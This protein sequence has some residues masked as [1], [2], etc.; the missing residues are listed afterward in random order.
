MDF[1]VGLDF[2]THQ[3]K[4]CYSYKPNN[5][6]L[7][8]Y[9]EF[10]DSERNAKSFFLPSVVQINDDDTMSYGYVNAG[11]CKYELI[12][13]PPEP[14]YPIKPE[15]FNG[16][17]PIR[18]PYPDKPVIKMTWRE[19]LASL[20]SSSKPE[21]PA[22]VEWRKNCE[23]IDHDYEQRL[24][25]WQSTKAASVSKYR[26]WERK[27][28]NMRQEYEAMRRQCPKGLP[29]RFFYFKLAS[30][31]E[32]YRMPFVGFL[33]DSDTISVL[34]LT[35]CILLIKQHLEQGYHA[36]FEDD[37]FIQMGAPFSANSAQA[38]KATEKGALLLN[39]S[40]SLAEK[41]RC[42][43]TFLKVKYYTLVDDVKTIISRNKRWENYMI[44]PEAFAGLYSA[45]HNKRIDPGMHILVDIGGGTTDVSFFTITKD[46][47][48]SIHML[49]SHHKGLNYV[50]ADYCDKHQGVR[51]EEAQDLLRHSPREFGD[52]IGILT[53]ELEQY[54]NAI[55]NTVRNEFLAKS[56]VHAL[57]VSRLYQALK[58]CPMI[59][60]GGG[61]M[62]DSL[63]FT[64]VVFSGDI[65]TLG[66]GLVGW[67]A[68]QNKVPD[69][70]F[71]M[72][73][74]A[75]GLAI[76]VPEPPVVL[77]I[78]DLFASMN[79]TS[80]GSTGI[81][82]S[83]NMSNSPISSCFTG[84]TSYFNDTYGLMDN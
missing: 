27:V 14:D 76:P 3:T 1:N 77:S 72:L 65:K 51:M 8:K 22:I 32:S 61:S 15:G 23:M 50:L 36:V 40:M 68:L 47:N 31:S 64:S 34:F 12:G 80:N 74:I 21:D 48:P 79:G 6:M 71:P 54:V 78:G 5:Q 82:S 45:T 42:L 43:D 49:L 46:R 84:G 2:G 59:F 53:S 9:M 4:I 19:K 20:F 70:L 10:V 39:T 33:K 13:C 7:F 58:K 57:P 55:V 18:M 35:Y 38:N 81:A 37:V 16:P 75:Y 83:G 24:I 29:Q 67:P 17:E 73:A 63:L 28:S 26:D 44:L 60:C 66:I 56:T 25:C 62:Y 69:N 30:F 11:I 41:Y 52:C